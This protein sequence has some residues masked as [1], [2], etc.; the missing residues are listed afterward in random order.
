MPFLPGQTVLLLPAVFVLAGCVAPV[1]KGKSPLDPARMSHDSVVLEIFF[2]RFP[3]ADADINGGLW[4]EIDEQHFPAELRS[5]LWRN[6][7]RVGLIDGQIPV[8]LSQ[9]MELTDR[10]PP[11]D[12]NEAQLDDPESDLPVRRHLQIRAGL[13]G[14]IVASG[15]YD[16]L[17]VL[18]CRPG[19]VGGQTYH[20]AQAILAAKAFPQHDGRVRLE[21]VPEVHHDEC[22][23]RW[24]VQQGMWRL[25]PGRPR[26]VFDEMRFSTVLS[27]GNILILSS[28]PNLPGS[29]GHHFFTEDDGQL[30]QKLLLVRLAQTQHHGMFTEPE[31]LQLEQ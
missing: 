17:P 13:R 24:V 12:G 29:L 20:K 31:V 4:Q 28:L 2:V 7:F 27:P 5:R 11:A 19:Q 16:R 30:Q 8:G 26:R 21:L 25:E 10:P 3:F 1:S 14:E 18:I 23:Q 9:L 22:R 15:Q 6:G